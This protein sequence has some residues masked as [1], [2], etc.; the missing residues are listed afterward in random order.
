MVVGCEASASTSSAASMRDNAPC[1]YRQQTVSVKP[2]FRGSILRWLSLNYD[3]NYG[4]SRLAVGDITNHNHSFNQKLYAS[5]IPEDRWEFSIGAE[6]FLTRFSEG[7]TENLI[8][9]DASA[10]WRLNS[11]I[12]L[13]LTANNLLNRRHYQYATYGTLSRSEHSFQIRPRNILASI[14]Y[15]F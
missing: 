4:F 8:L 10:V 7:N 15:R 1:D 11:K 3:A 9:L 6:H 13:S 14:Q 12:R 2:Y 5:I